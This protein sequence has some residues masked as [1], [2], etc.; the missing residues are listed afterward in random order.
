MMTQIQKVRSFHHKQKFPCDKDLTSYE[1]DKETNHYLD[2][3]ASELLLSAT[4]MENRMKHEDHYNLRVAR[5]QLMI[6][7]LGETILGLAHCDEILTLDGLSDLEFVTIGTAISF[8]LPLSEGLEEVC[9]SN[10]TKSPHEKDDSRIRGKGSNFRPP[11]LK[12]V[13]SLH[14]G[15]E[16]LAFR[17]DCCTNLKKETTV[18]VKKYFNDGLKNWWIRLKK[19]G[20][21]GYESIEISKIPER[22]DEGWLACMGTSKLWDELFLPGDSM[23]EIL[24]WLKETE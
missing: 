8:G 24:T 3:V 21:T 18:L 10:L 23:Q 6:E 4:M 19:G 16:V 11:N 12:K 7:E 14:R 15:V 5:T 22:L 2:E 13:M 17:T 9:D 1:N 20:V